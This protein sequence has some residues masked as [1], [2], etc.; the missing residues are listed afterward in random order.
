MLC[1]LLELMMAQRCHVLE[2]EAAEKIS[3]PSDQKMLTT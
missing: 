1:S 2:Q 3:L